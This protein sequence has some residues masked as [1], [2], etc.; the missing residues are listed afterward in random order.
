MKLNQKHLTS[1]FT[2]LLLALIPTTATAHDFEIDGIYYLIDGSNATVTFKGQLPHSYSNEY[3]G[4]VVI[5]ETVT[6]GGITYSV[7]SIGEYAFYGCYVLTSITIPNSVTSIG[8]SAFKGCYGMTSVNIP[9]SLSSIGNSAFHSC[10]GLTGELVIPNTVTSI[11]YEAFYDCSGL[12]SITIPNSVSSIGGYTFYGCRGLTSITIPNSVTSIGN[13]AFLGCLSLTNIT[14]PDSVTSIGTQ[15]FDLCRSLTSVTIGSS[16]TSIGS[17]AFSNCS[18]LT[19][20]N[21]NAKSCASFT[22][23][24]SSQPFNGLTGITMINIGNEV[25]NIPDY[26]CYGL[27]GLTNITIPSSVSTIGN[28]TFGNCAGIKTL[29]WNAKLCSSM[30]SMPKSNIETVT[31]GNQVQTLPDNFVSG[32]KINS[33]TIPN[34]VISIG[35]RAFSSCNG[36]TSIT[37][38]NSVTTIGDNAF[39]SCSGLTSVSI[40]NSVTTIGN[41]AFY[42]CNGLTSV[43][44]PNSVTSIGSNAFKGC[45]GLTSTHISDLASW[46]K[47]SFGDESANPLNYA[48]HLYLNN[49]EITNLVVPNSVS[50]VG[51]YA[52]VSCTGLTSVTLPNSLASIGNGSFQGCTGLKN[53]TIPKQVTYIGGNAFI[54]T[55]LKSVITRPTTPPTISGSNAFSSGIPI[56]IPMGTMSAY[57]NANYWK[58]YNLRYSMTKVTPYTTQMAIVS[59]DKEISHLVKVRVSNKEYSV[60]NDSIMITGLKPGEN[61]SVIAVCNV[62][63][64][65]R[66][67]TITVTTKSVRFES[68]SGSST[69]TTITPKF[70]VYRDDAGLSVLSCG[71]SYNGKDYTSKVVETTDTYYVIEANPITG[72]NPSTKYYYTP[73]IVCNGK[74][75][76]GPQYNITTKNIGTSSNATTGPTNVEM[77][78]SYNAGDAHVKESYF[79]FNGTKMKKISVTGLKPSTT[80]ST[81]YTVVTNNGSVNTNMSFKTKDLT[82]TTQEARMLSDTSPMLIAATNIAD[83]ETSCGFEWRRYDAPDEM[84]SAKVYCPVYGGTMA[85][86]L[87]NMSPNVYYKYRPFYKASDG[88]EYYGNWIAFITA[89]AGVTFEPVVYTYKSP[90]VTQNTA[91]LQ[92]VALPGSS[93]ITDQGFEYWRMTGSKA[94]TGTVNKV[95]ATGQRMSATVQGLSAGATYG[96]RSYVIA[97]GQTYYGS[98]EQFTTEKA[99]GDVNG[100]GRVN[101]SDVSALINMILGLQPMDQSLGDVNGDGRVNVSDV[102]ALINIILGIQ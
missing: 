62:L 5:P 57:K 76:V 28:N 9:D 29:T 1:L 6:Y 54:N 22:S 43:V 8:S 3:K 75:C 51:N 41:S 20:I 49:N 77:T 90:E 27:L 63:G 30:G 100:D 25:K 17:D 71:A 78:G 32:S 70:K 45:G 52:F 44:I 81:V 40:G 38:P 69:Q 12:T 86:V 24:A 23:N 42:G 87:K 35:N 88:S 72:L 99:S 50:T 36:L 33:V 92:G 7:T 39:S 83:V 66:T 11:S 18:G 26:L 47:I 16:V 14:I 10:S 64:D 102:S 94:P 34:T 67:D 4:A 101:V 60:N 55:G 46:C 85:G 21:W 65:E 89:D 2:A 79:T 98:E 48:H 37:I 93:D 13:M 91:T 31:I 74:R 61:L 56:F 58:N 73:W 19:T 68:V 97:G 96:Y 80:Y 15:A 84:P 59:E 53:L 82:M 95:T